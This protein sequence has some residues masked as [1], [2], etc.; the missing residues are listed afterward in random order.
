MERGGYETAT[1]DIDRASEFTGDDVDQYSSLVDLNGMFTGLSIILPAITSSAINIYIQE[2][3]VKTTV[4]TVVHY[5]QTSDNATAAWTTTASAGA[6]AITCDN[7]PVA[8]FV[9]IRCTTNQ[10]ADRAIKVCGFN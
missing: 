6:C 5:R 9:R 3:G 4:P 2:G 8:R 10:G 1:I 7:L